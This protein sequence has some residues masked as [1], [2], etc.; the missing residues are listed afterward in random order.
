[1]A[2]NHITRPGW[3]GLTCEQ[4]TAVISSELMPINQLTGADRLCDTC[5]RNAEMAF[6]RAQLFDRYKL[7]YS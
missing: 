6:T 4:E 3:A 1:M 7:I 2:I 5:L